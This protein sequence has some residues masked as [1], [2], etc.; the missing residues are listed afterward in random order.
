MGEPGTSGA[1]DGFL[2]RAH[3]SWGA[4]H[5]L[6]GLRQPRRSPR[7]CV[8]YH[9]GK[10]SRKERTKTSVIKQAQP[11]DRSRGLFVGR[12]DVDMSGEDG[13]A[14]CLVFLCWKLLLGRSR[15]SGSVQVI[16]L[17]GKGCSL[18]REQGTR[19]HVF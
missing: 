18:A 6:R 16:M 9:P 2:S 7:A 4:A 5:D 19:F 13:L 12:D 17:R 3:N 10:G 11:S 14:K 1:I 8:G 15:S